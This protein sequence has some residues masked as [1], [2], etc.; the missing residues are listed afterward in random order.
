M[1]RSTLLAGTYA[2]YGPPSGDVAIGNA[3]NE[4]LSVAVP[5]ADHGH[6]F[7]APPAN[8]VQPLA[9][10]ESDGV[11]ATAARSDHKH[12]HVAA[13]HGSG[14]FADLSA[15]FAPL[16][17]N[18]RLELAGPTD[19]AATAGAGTALPATPEAYLEVTVAGTVRKI[20][21]YPV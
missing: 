9:A 15:L 8:Y 4:G 16:D 2:N 1:F 11:D 10:A 20:P 6:A 12:P 17:A 21:F 19:A 5:R 13:D 3:E 18:E 7:P 14:G